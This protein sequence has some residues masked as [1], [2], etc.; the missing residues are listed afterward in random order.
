[1]TL[2]EWLGQAYGS[3]ATLGS[4]A[5][6]AVIGAVASGRTCGL[7][8]GAA[9]VGVA[10]DDELGLMAHPRGALDGRDR[11]ALLTALRKLADEET[12]VRFVVGLPLDMHG[13]EGAAARRAR[14]TAQAIANATGRDVELWDERL[15]TVQANRAL[16]DSGVRGRD[17]R[18]RIDEAAACAIL[19]AWM[20]ARRRR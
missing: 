12:V 8:L 17:R 10:I 15:T 2:S 6:G 3:A 5:G 20:D 1:M 4:A 11:K 7:D 19:Q 16:R 13:G 14:E 9:R 18:E